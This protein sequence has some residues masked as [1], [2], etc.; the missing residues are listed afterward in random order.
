MP[1]CHVLTKGVYDL[2]SRER[3]AAERRAS[4]CWLARVRNRSSPKHSHRLRSE[5]AWRYEEVATGHD[6]MITEPDWLAY[7]LLDLVPES[8]TAQ[9]AIRSSAPTRPS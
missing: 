2:L 9:A 5:S 3:A 8:V 6:V 1:S 4:M 7:L